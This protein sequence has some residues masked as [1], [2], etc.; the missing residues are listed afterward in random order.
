MSQS[1]G[2]IAVSLRLITDQAKKDLAD[3]VREFGLANSK[4][5]QPS[6]ATSSAA[7]SGHDKETVAIQKKTKALTEQQKVLEAWRDEGGLQGLEL[8]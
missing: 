5:A 2:E 3:Y 8:S 1:D 6:A 4:A 7:V